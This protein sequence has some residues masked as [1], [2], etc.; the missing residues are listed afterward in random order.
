MLKQTHD[1]A[2]PRR[3]RVDN[4]GYSHSLHSTKVEAPRGA[5][6]WL[7]CGARL[8]AA[9]RSSSDGVDAGVR[10]AHR[11]AGQLVGICRDVGGIFAGG[12]W[13]ETRSA[14][15]HISR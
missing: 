8:L 11:L 14:S 15:S 7:I 3:D 5:S 9:H 6:W 4:V 1:T 13:Y 2:R 10:Q 12:I